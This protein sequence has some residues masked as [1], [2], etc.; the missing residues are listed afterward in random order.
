MLF[1]V[2]ALALGGCGSLSGGLHSDALSLAAPPSMVAAATPDEAIAPARDTEAA[3]VDT[4]AAVVVDATSVER[5]AVTDLA[6]AVGES[7][8]TPAAFDIVSLEPLRD[9][10]FSPVFLALDGSMMVAQAPSGSRP[11]Q[12]PLD[13]AIEEYD[14]WESFNESMF[15]FN[16]NLDTYVLKPAAQAYNFVVPDEL[17]QMIDRG[18]ENIRVVPR[19]VNNLLQ[20]KWAGAGREIARFLINSVVGIGGLWDMAKQEWGIEKSKEDFGQ[21]LGVWGAGPGPYLILPFLP[22]MTI[23][24]GIGTAVDGAMDPLSYFLP[25]IWERFAMKAGDIVNDRSLNLELFEGVEETTVDLYTAVRNAYLQ[26]RA[27]QIKE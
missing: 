21:T 22:P 7:V 12:P 11:S 25:F 2:L 8:A 14:P 27:R 9:E 5:V 6:V 13:P 18:F 17:Q 16:R 3:V 23:R 10:P 1:G 20:A 4:E 24:D 26:R 19:V 15:T